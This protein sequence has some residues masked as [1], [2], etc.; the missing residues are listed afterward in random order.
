M[1]HVTI[2]I[3]TVLVASA[4]SAQAPREAHERHRIQMHLAHVASVLRARRLD[5]LSSAQREARNAA[6]EMLDVYTAAGEFPKNTEQPDRYG[7]VF[8]DEQGTACAV[9][10]LLIA[11]GQGISRKQSAHART[12]P[13][14]PTSRLPVS[15]NG[16]SSTASHSTSWR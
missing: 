10:Y 2:A 5:H 4:A 8:I 6:L 16:P 15:S 11:T 12:T 3:A 7:P 1:R 13:T 9:G 14:S